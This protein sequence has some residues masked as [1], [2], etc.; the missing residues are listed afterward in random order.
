MQR[1][2]EGK[3]EKKKEMQRKEKEENVCTC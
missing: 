2:E 1:K 3:R